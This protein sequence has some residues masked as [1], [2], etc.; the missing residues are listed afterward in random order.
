VDA[1]T[2][3]AFTGWD[4][5]QLG[6]SVDGKER[7]ATAGPKKTDR[8]L[9]VFVSADTALV[10]SRAKLDA[11]LDAYAGKT[12]SFRPAA[13][14]SAPGAP[15]LRIEADIEALKMPGDAN[16]LR[17]GVLTLGETGPNL[18]ATLDGQ[19][20][21][22]GKATQVASQAKGLAV[23]LSTGLMDETDKTPDQIAGQR[24]MLELIQSLKT[25]A[26]GDHAVFMLSYDAEKAALGLIK[27]VIA[28]KVKS[29]TGK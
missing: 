13:D 19:V 4:V 26:K 22:A 11:A 18:V 7:V 1:V 5:D 12:A 14:L 6:S 17:R 10:G 16:G 28:Q 3:G 29:A 15:F 23:L 25:E 9:I 24:A 21:S 8:T 2:L 20:I 27:A